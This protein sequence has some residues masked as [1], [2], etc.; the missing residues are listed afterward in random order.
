[1]NVKKLALHR[2]RRLFRLA[3]ETAQTDLN[4]SQRYVEIARKIAM[5]ARVRIPREY[6]RFICKR[7]KSFILPGVNSRVRIQQK[8]EP[9]I[10]ITC[11][12]CGHVTRLPLR[13]KK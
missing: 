4:Q 2:I 7:C 12:I 1:M 10:A 11:L 5:K 3:I 9:H 13:C 8:R 6:R